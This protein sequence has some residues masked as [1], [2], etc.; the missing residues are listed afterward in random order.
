MC[1]WI[2]N[3]LDVDWE[4]EGDL[5]DDAREL[6]NRFI[7]TTFTEKLKKDGVQDAEDRV[8]WFK[9]WAALQSV[10]GMDHVHVLLRDVPEH[11]IVE[12]TGEKSVKR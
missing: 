7:Q 5:T 3:R 4:R 10:R 1:V 2:K 9:N 8:M 12:W 6:V 11:L